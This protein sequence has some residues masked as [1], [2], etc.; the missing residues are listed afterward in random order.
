MPSVGAELFRADRQA[1]IQ[2]DGE[3]DSQGED[4]VRFS[5]LRERA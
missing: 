3:T 2:T 1:H 4:N 5:Q